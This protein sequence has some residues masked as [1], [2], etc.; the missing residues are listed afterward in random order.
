MANNPGL[1]PPPRFTRG[2][3]LTAEDMNRI[4]AMLVRR[5]EGGKGITVKSFGSRIVIE[6]NEA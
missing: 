2:S 4:V 6:S 3:V 5:I 1:V